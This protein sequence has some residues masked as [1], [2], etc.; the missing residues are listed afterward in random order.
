MAGGCARR[1][2]GDSHREAPI[3]ATILPPSGNDNPWRGSA[4]SGS[5]TP[6]SEN[7]SHPPESAPSPHPD[8]PPQNQMEADPGA[9][10]TPTNPPAR[11]VVDVVRGTAPTA[12]LITRVATH[13]AHRRKRPAET[14]GNQN[15]WVAQKFKGFD[16]YRAHMHRKAGL[17]GSQ[18]PV[19]AGTA[20]A[21]T[22]KV[23]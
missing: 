10:L 12:Q 2:R 22:H 18:T 14:Q 16:S 6:L 3:S 4:H 7:L 11:N 5:H 21:G 15:K 23:I 19:Y 17:W 13:K 1:E 8:G 9:A 20:T